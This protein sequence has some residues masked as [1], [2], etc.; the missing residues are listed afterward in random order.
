MS[1]G[2]E[3]SEAVAIPESWPYEPDVQWLYERPKMPI[4]GIAGPFGSGKDEAARGIEHMIRT[5]SRCPYSECKV[6]KFADGVREGLLRIDPLVHGETRLS[7]IVADVGWEGAKQYDEYR[8]LMQRFGDEAGRALHGHDTWVTQ[9][10]KTINRYEARGDNERPKL[11]LITDVRYPNE[12]D[13]VNKYGLGC[14]YVERPGIDASQAARQHASESHFAEI[15]AKSKRIIVNDGTIDDLHEKARWAASRILMELFCELEDDSEFCDKSSR[16]FR[17]FHK[18]QAI[19][20]MSR[21]CA[22]DG[23]IMAFTDASESDREWCSIHAATPSAVFERHLTAL[24]T[25]PTGAE[26]ESYYVPI[27]SHNGLF[28][29]HSFE[30]LKSSEA[31]SHDDVCVRLRTGH[32]IAKFYHDKLLRLPGCRYFLPAVT[33]PDYSFVHFRFGTDYSSPLSGRG[34]L[35]PLSPPK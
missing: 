15:K 7:Q 10:Q 30:P 22:T 12:I 25:V 16:E 20:D 23:C 13:F 11:Y 21:I 32:Y 4:I 33:K 17:Q 14:I 1:S 8:R 27:T 9:A 31:Y 5:P 29:E 26:D 6:V 28:E 2:T 3:V 18:I 24:S 34:V 35:A 19:R